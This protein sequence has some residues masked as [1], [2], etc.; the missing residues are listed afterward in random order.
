MCTATYLQTNIQ[1][2]THMHT[3]KEY[4]HIYIQINLN[5]CALLSSQPML[6]PYIIYVKI[7][8]YVYIHMSAFLMCMCT[9]VYLNMHITD[10]HY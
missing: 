5:T 2:Q 8:M 1:K 4:P 6:T 7:C 3:I 9:V 10:T